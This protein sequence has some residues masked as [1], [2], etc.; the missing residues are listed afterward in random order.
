MRQ[1][2]IPQVSSPD[3]R[4]LEERETGRLHHRAQT[5]STGS[6]GFPPSV[7]RVPCG[8]QKD[9]DVYMTRSSIRTFVVLGG[10]F[11]FLIVGLVGSVLYLNNGVMVYTIDDVYI[12]LAMARNIAFH[13]T[14]G[15]NPATYESASSSPAF[16]FGLAFFIRLLPKI[17]NWLPLF[18]NVAPGIW[19]LYR[20][21]TLPGFLNSR[22]RQ[23]VT[24]AILAVL[25]VALYLP[26]LAMIG[27]EHTLHAAISL[28]IL[29][30]LDRWTRN[31]LSRSSMFT[32][33]GL[34]ALVPL[35]RFEAIFLAIGCA[36]ALMIGQSQ[37]DQT[38]QS[39]LVRLSLA[40]VRPAIL[41]LLAAGAPV[42][43][44]GLVNLAHGQYFFPN[45]V[46]YKTGLGEGLA[47]WF[48][49][50]VEFVMKLQGDVM[51]FALV[52]LVVAY[53]I[54]SFHGL[55]SEHVPVSVAYFI[56]A[57]MHL[58]FAQI[59]WFDRYQAYL[60]ITGTFLALWIVSELIKPEWYAA[61]ASIVLL[62]LIILPAHQYYTISVVPLASNNIY[63]Q[64]YQMGRFFGQQYR[65]R[66][67]AVNDLGLVSYLHPGAVVDLIGLGSHT[68]LRSRKEGHFDSA[69]LE[70]LVRA[71][72]VRAVAIYDR[73][74]DGMIPSSWIKVA[75]WSLGRRR[76]T[77]ADS[78]V[79]FYAPS[80]LAADTLARRMRNFAPSL[81]TGVGV[82]YFR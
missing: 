8:S 31:G 30:L 38:N 69:Y 76:V 32:Y 55:R 36:V 67:V 42:F 29:V 9:S 70:S 81:P 17:A 56:A 3:P 71:N 82:T 14:Y 48:P 58:A 46:V 1:S 35:I 2:P 16:T 57:T 49:H 78:V 62:L 72:D 77:P 6:S 21:A 75:Q 66:P 52:I 68:V 26:G 74:F 43:L 15:I 64:Q 23:P 18:L 44:A 34:V 65:E 73:W 20:F 41:T 12:H 19:I 60:L 47:G 10:S 79:S 59:G 39:S 50:P 53:L 11:L 80:P 61:A 51:L 13:G 4:T 7:D 5:V 45:S 25:P 24:L 33:Y 37:P 40:G 63:Q 27:M 54:V 22:S 28:E